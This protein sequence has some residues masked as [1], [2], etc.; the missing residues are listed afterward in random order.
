MQLSDLQ[1]SEFILTKSG[2]CERLVDQF[3]FSTEPLQAVAHVFPNDAD[4][5]TFAFA[6]PDGHRIEQRTIASGVQQPTKFIFRQGSTNAPT[7]RL[8]VRLAESRE[9][10]RH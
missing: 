1:R 3:A 2:Q 4:C 8:L 7:I 10:I 6:A 5:L 9:R